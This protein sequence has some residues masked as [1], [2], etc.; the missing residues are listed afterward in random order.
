MRSPSSDRGFHG[1]KAAITF[2]LWCAVGAGIGWLAGLL[3]SG[4]TAMTRVEEVL[5]GIFGAFAGG[6]FL[7]TL[8]TAPAV[9]AAPPA[10]G[11]KVV[12][13][14]FTFS[15]MAFAM[16]IAGAIAMLLLLN[17]MRKAVGPMR[18]GKSKSEGRR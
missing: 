12:E 15:I 6:E 2:I 1:Q 16:G 8:M 7:Y 5:V 11:V 13:P 10:F 4:G 17:L 9:A 18:A 3:R 14:P